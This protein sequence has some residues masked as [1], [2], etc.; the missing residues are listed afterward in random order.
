MATHTGADMQAGEQTSCAM[1]A[2]D[3]ASWARKSLHVFSAT[4]CRFFASFAL[5]SAWVATASSA[6]THG[7]K[8]G[9]QGWVI[10]NELRLGFSN[11]TRNPERTRD[12]RLPATVGLGNT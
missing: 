1:A 3:C 5:R 12:K 4:S 9:K 6:V 10:A 7:S 8:H 11:T 2:W